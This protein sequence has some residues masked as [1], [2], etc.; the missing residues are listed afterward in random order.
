MNII[1]FPGKNTPLKRYK[2]YFK[3]YIL[4]ENCN[5]SNHSVIVCHSIGIDKALQQNREF[6]IIAL[7]PTHLCVGNRVVKSWINSK[8]Y[9]NIEI[10]GE[11]ITIEWYSEDTHYPYQIKRV[12]DR[13]L[14]QINLF[15]YI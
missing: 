7:D 10:D 4:T 9:G 15:A 6:P 12:K 13:I 1:F 8:R 2:S 5:D 14:S 3:P 11:N